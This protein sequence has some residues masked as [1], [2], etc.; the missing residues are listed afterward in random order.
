MGS[1][2]G[3]SPPSFD[4]F[5]YLCGIVLT[6]CWIQPSAPPFAATYMTYLRFHMVFVDTC[7]SEGPGYAKVC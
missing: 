5:L 2:T 7:F 6:K 1:E 4:D 3:T